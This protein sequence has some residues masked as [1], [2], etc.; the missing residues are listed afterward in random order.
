MQDLIG[1]QIPIVFTTLSTAIPQM[2]SGKI[3]VIGSSSEAPG[4]HAGGADGRRVGAG[5]RHAEFPARFFGPA[6]LPETIVTRLNG[7]I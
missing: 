5:L 1:G 3:R 4:E 6:G 7:E 2:R